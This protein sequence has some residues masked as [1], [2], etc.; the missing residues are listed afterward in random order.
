MVLHAEG[1]YVYGDALVTV[2]NVQVT[3]DLSLAKIYLSIYNSENKQA[4]ILQMEE[5]KHRLKQALASRVKR[6]L[7]RIP[8]IDFYI[9]ETLD[10]VFKLDQLF[11]RLRDEKQMGEE[12]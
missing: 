1:T 7:R 12:E 8:D 9:D 5:H 3:P 6:H 4:V 11:R 2:T 10:E